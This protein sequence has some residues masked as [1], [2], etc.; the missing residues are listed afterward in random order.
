MAHLRWCAGIGRKIDTLVGEQM[1]RKEN[2][3]ADKGWGKEDRL[4]H[5]KTQHQSAKAA[6]APPN[7]PPTFRAT[8][9]HQPFPLLGG[10]FLRI[11]SLVVVAGILPHTGHC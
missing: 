6:D 7:P 2:L 1:Q 11:G 10:T 8:I 3:A 5:D 9:A 4:P